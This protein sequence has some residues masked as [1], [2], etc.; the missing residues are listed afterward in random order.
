M[1]KWNEL[2]MADRARYIR[3]GVKVGVT[4]LNKIRDTYNTYAYG[5]DTSVQD[6]QKNENRIVYYDPITGENFGSTMPEGKVKVTDFRQ[7]T[8]EA[9]DE[10]MRN[11]SK[12][13]DELVV[14]PTSGKGARSTTMRR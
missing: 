10:Y 2:S 4:D 3:M 11:H 12:T 6:K 7:L 14:Y 5:G 9:Q 1:N 13:L 8:P